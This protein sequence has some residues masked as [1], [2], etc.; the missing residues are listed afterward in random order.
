M[1][2]DFI[3]EVKRTLA[4]RVGNRCSN[5]NCHALTSG[6]QDDPAKALNVGVAAH[7]TAAA[8]GGPR[9]DS[10]LTSEERCHPDNGIWL[11]QTCAKLVDNDTSQFPVDLL[12]AWKTI[13]EH[14]ARSRIGKTALFVSTGSK[15]A[16]D[17]I[18]QTSKPPSPS[19]NI[20]FVEAGVVSA[21]SGT[22]GDKIIYK[23]PQ[24]LGDF[25]VSVACF[26]NEAVAGLAVKEPHLK[27]HIIYRGKDGNE[28]TD[29]PRAVWLEEYGESI[30]F[31]TG[32]RKCIIV[33]LLSSQDTLLKL[34]N[35]RYTTSTSWMAGGPLFRVRTERVETEVSLIEISLLSSDGCLLVAKF[36][37]EE[38][39]HG[40]LP[41][42]VLRSMSAGNESSPP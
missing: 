21:H 29:V 10:L 6:P 3:E 27:A 23:S 32:K 4:A 20:R 2:D 40:E 28:I 35:E 13:A 14:D 36:E 11:C 18:V 39:K 24:N 41:E 8:Q 37:V 26:R 31:E 30:L 22:G 1:R 17:Q 25:N 33:F 12:R 19:H 42:L 7:I 5:P 16:S 38:R 9:Y 15:S 34:W